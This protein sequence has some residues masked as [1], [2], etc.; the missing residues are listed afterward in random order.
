MIAVEGFRDGGGDQ[1]HPVQVISVLAQGLAGDELFRNVSFL[2]FIMPF[3]IDVQ[4]YALAAA[5]VS[6]AEDAGVLGDFPAIFPEAVQEKILVGQITLAFQPVLQLLEYLGGGPLARI[7]Q[8]AGIVRGG[9]PAVK[10]N[11]IHFFDLLFFFDLSQMDRVCYDR[12][13]TNFC[14]RRRRLWRSGPIW[15]WI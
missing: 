1:E 13:R 7:F 10:L 4:V 15:Q 9:F 3:E 8:F 5:V 2:A 12:T 6:G 11:D 14:V